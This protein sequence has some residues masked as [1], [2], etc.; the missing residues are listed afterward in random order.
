MATKK[1][2]RAR[3]GTR[4]RE[5]DI[6]DIIVPEVRSSPLF[7]PDKRWIGAVARYYDDVTG[8]LAAIREDCQLPK[9]FFVPDLWD[10]S[11]RLP[12][13]ER[14]MMLDIW[15]LGH[16]L[17]RSVGYGHADPTD[18]IRNRVG[19]TVYTRS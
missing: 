6:A 1:I 18:F 10:T 4:E 5:V 16:A 3:G 17:A 11:F 12:K 19:G 8:L 2:V 7:L 14:E 9:E 13:E 15:E